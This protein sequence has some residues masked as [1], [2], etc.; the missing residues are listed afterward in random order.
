MIIERQEEVTEAVL[1]AAERTAD[2]RLREILCALVRHLHAF[3]REVH[4]TEDE[5]H[6]AAALVNQLGQHSDD[7]HNESILAAGT[8]GLSSL[9]CLLNNG[10]GGRRPT[11]QSLLGPFWRLAAPRVGRG[12]SI[13][14]SDTPGPALLVELTV[15]DP[16]GAPV[17]GADVDVWQASPVG[18]YENQD[19]DQAPM[20][21][22][23]ILTTG[24]DGRVWF[25]TVRP[26]GY[27]VPTNGVVGKLL[28]AQGR[29]PY[30]PAHLHAMVVKDGYK[31]LTSQIYDADDPRLDTDAQF[32]VTRAAV[33]RL[34]RHDEACAEA[35][36]LGVPWY[37]LSTILVI[38]PGV[39][40]L[41]RPPIR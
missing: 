30:R 3:V 9:V 24:G 36:D 8:L 21:L 23:G 20:N 25:R 28:R 37:S 10:D 7:R 14:R 32:G 16:D 13:V 4:L 39:S 31:T 12:G 19:P 33:G 41:P 22:R 18:L 11:S 15:V 40:R 35:P 17:E 2:P 1:A 6:A 29:H 26:S 27:P 38:E 34:E 5:L